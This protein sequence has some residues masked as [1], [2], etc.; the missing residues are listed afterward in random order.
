M[1]D[2]FHGSITPIVKVSMDKAKNSMYYERK[3]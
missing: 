3:F 1:K 2:F